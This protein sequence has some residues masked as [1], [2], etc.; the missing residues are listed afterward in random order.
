MH[1]DT[2]NLNNA[3]HDKRE[4]WNAKKAEIMAHN[5]RLDAEARMEANNALEDLSAEFDAAADWTEAAWNEFSAKVSKV[6][7]AGEVEVDEAI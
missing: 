7:N 2:P 6:W 1:N 5:D 3:A 4:W